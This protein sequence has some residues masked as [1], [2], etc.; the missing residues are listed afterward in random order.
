MKKLLYILWL[1]GAPVT[2]FAQVALRPHEQVSVRLKPSDSLR[3]HALIRCGI[4]LVNDKTDSAV[5]LLS[6]AGAASRRAEYAEGIA[7]SLMALSSCYAVKNDIPMATRC[8]EQAYPYC[9]APSANSKLL[10]KWYRNRFLVYKYAGQVDSA[11]GVIRK[12]LPL[13]E[14]LQDTSYAVNTYNH[15]GAILIDNQDYE[16][17]YT[18]TCK[19][20]QLN[21]GLNNDKLVSWI[22]LGYIYANRGDRDSLFIWAT[23]ASEGAQQLQLPR[24]E[25]SAALLLV[26]YYLSKGIETMADRYARRA[27]QLIDT[28][29]SDNRLYIY[30]I[31]CKEYLDKER[32][33]QALTYGNM[34]LEQVKATQRQRRDVIYIYALLAETYH[35]LGN[36]DMA[37][38]FLLQYN[39]LSDSLN[40]LERDKAVDRLEQQFRLAE[41]EK[42]IAKQQRE[43]LLQQQ[44]IRNRNIG[45]IIALSGLV[46]LVVLL[47]VLQKSARRRM[48]LLRH[49][50]EIHELKAMISGE[51]RE[52]NRLAI[53]LHDNVG[54]LLSA[55]SYSLDSAKEREH[56]FQQQEDLGKIGAII[57]GIRSEIRRTAHTLMPDVLL[58][59]SLPEAVRQYCAFIERD[60]GLQVSMQ[61]QGSFEHLSQEAQLSV[62]RIVQ[63]LLQNIQKH[64]GAT[65]ALVQLHSGNGIVSLTVEDNGRGMPEQPERTGM[66]LQ[67]IA[68][69]LKV[70][71][72]SISFDSEAGKGTSV[73]VELNI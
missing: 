19:A 45:I 72:G 59:H 16:K 30:R 18:Y 47:I 57:V 8:L 53:E 52:R 37:Y 46:V 3:I 34:A 29:A 36:G 35:Q 11:M 5:L 58:R 2:T 50:K 48:Q 39:A 14:Q 41:K 21:N 71:E 13:V 54:A 65:S 67:N 44:G 61:Q 63:E 49:Q 64:A 6:E 42:Q 66:G 9:T 22:N 4:D 7:L 15:I 27:I 51:E 28:Q 17:A 38:R 33:T 62:Y 24:Y 56:G 40:L 60:T 10:I 32:Y 31:L 68:R 43:A 12:A 23:K 26:R 70:M 69:R 1:L 73:Y 25:R 55:A 20:L